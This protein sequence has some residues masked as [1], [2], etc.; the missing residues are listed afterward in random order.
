MSSYIP[1]GWTISWRVRW[2][3][4]PVNQ[5]SNNI[6]YFLRCSCV[7]CHGSLSQELLNEPNGLP[8]IC[9]GAVWN[10]FDLMEKG[11]TE[12]ANTQPGPRKC[13]NALERF[14]LLQLQTTLAVGAAYMGAK[15]AKIDFPREYGRNSKVFFSKTT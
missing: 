6:F 14:S 1:R 10:S 3:F 11:F 15:F 9:V 12:G 8:I 2:R 5:Q 4:T 13:P 7:S